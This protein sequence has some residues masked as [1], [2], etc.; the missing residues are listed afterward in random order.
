LFFS[1]WPALGYLLSFWKLGYYYCPE[2]DA[3]ARIEIKKGC[4]NC[5]R[6]STSDLEI[7]SFSICLYL[8]VRKSKNRYARYLIMQSSI[9]KIELYEEIGDIISLMILEDG[10]Q[11]G[12][13][14]N[15]YGGTG[16]NVCLTA[17]NSAK[18]NSATA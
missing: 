3:M 11:F 5:F 9:L 13:L 14:R 7:G 1:E 8:R 18:Q 17:L 15:L 2:N 10:N 16:P 4:Y 12:F 6:V